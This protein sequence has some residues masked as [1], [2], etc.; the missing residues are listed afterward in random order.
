S[1][2]RWK[3]N[4]TAQRRTKR[5]R[6]IMWERLSVAEEARVRTFRTEHFRELF[7]VD[8]NREMMRSGGQ[9][10]LDG[11]L[12]HERFA[13]EPRFRGAGE[14]Q[15]GFAGIRILELS[16]RIDDVAGIGQ[17]LECFGK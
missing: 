13:V 11:R 16:D 14:L 17:K 9:I 10:D 7:Y 12:H 4:A 2:A 8:L 1:G 3:K 6:G 5:D 15:P